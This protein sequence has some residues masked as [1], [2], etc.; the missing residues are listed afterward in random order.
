[1]RRKPRAGWR[2]C[3]GMMKQWF[4]SQSNEASDDRFIGEFPAATQ[5]L[6]ELD[7]I[8]VAQLRQSSRSKYGLGCSIYFTRIG[9]TDELGRLENILSERLVIIGSTDWHSHITLAESERMY[10]YGF[11]GEGLYFLGSSFGEGVIRRLMAMKIRPVFLTDSQDPE[12]EFQLDGLSP[13]D[14]DVLIPSPESGLRDVDTTIY[15]E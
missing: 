1:M 10:E 12:H 6:D 11:V 3:F 5:V 8:V 2:S 7:G 9:R 13:D 14:P 15:D 4:T